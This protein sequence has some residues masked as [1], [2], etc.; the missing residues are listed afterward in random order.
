MGSTSTDLMA[1]IFEL[2]IEC[3]QQRDS[4]NAQ[5][6]HFA[7]VPFVLMNGLSGALLAR[8]D[9]LTEDEDN[10]WWISIV[11][12]LEGGNVVQH[13]EKPELLEEIAHVLYGRLKSTSGY[14]FAL[15]GTEVA[16]FNT[17]HNLNVLINH[18]KLHGLV[19]RT[20]IFMSLGKP[21]GFE[22]FSQNYVW[23]PYSQYSGRRR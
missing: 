13:F 1:W 11:P 9:A 10:N 22:F 18:P 7:N 17:F 4:A 19:L 23:K 14:R 8:P 20:D 3:G 6:S 5:M 21:T 2:A 15:V 12:I 16:Q